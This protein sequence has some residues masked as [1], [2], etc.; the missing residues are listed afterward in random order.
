MIKK[1]V[2]IH[3][4][5][6]IVRGT[7]LYSMNGKKCQNAIYYL[8]QKNRDMISKFEEQGINS[9]N[10]TF[11]S[12]RE[13]MGLEKDNNYVAIIKEG[14]REL[15]DTAIELNNWTNPVT[16]KEYSWYR[17]KFINDSSV[18]KDNTLVVTL[19]IGTLAKQLMRAKGNFT[20]LDLIKYMNRFRTKYAMKIY[21]YLESFKKYRYLDIS[22]KH[23]MK[24]LNIAEND[25][26]NK[27]YSNLKR[28]LERQLQDIVLKS[29][30]K[31]VKL[32]SS[33]LLAKK[34]AKEKMYRIII[35]PNGIKHATKEEA[36]T[37][38]DNLIKRF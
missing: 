3:K 7:D 25:K 2:T 20:E 38:L 1:Q 37:A 26:T 28:L 30:L 22:Q 27:H 14:I 17:T 32:Q 15:Q 9:M 35:N 8:Y 31:D 13:Y 33:K 36:K 18:E 6:E 29:D 16:G 19:E 12:L 23:L 4:R 24:L 5:N 10:I 11:A 21:E 34:L